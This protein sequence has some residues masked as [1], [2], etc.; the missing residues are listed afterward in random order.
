MANG[1]SVGIWG[2]KMIFVKFPR[3][4]EMLIPLEPEWYLIR[5][6][7]SQLKE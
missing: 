4:Q 2:L 5:Y 6:K 7:V 1:T 3:E